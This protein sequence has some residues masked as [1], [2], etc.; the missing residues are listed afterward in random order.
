MKHVYFFFLLFA[1][2]RVGAQAVDDTATTGQGFAVVIPV[3]ANDNF[4]EATL[5]TISILSPAQHGE[6]AIEGNMTPAPDDDTILYVPDPGFAGEDSFVYTVTLVGGTTYS[7][8]VSI[9][10]VGDAGGPVANP[11]N[12]WGSEDTPMILDILANDSFGSEGPGTFVLGE[13]QNGSTAV[14]LQNDTPND[15]T[16]DTILYTP[17][18]NFNG[19]D[20]FNYTITSAFGDASTTEVSITVAPDISEGPF[21]MDDLVNTNIDTPVEII[22]LMNDSLG[23]NDLPVVSIAQPPSNGVVTL[24]TF[25]TPYANDDTF[26]Y[27]PNSGFVGTD[28]FLYAITDITGS[29]YATVTVIVGGN[30]ILLSAFYDND[31]DGVQDENETN[32]DFGTF[33]YEVNG[34]GI[35]HQV[36]ASNG[37]YYIDEDDPTAVYD[38]GYAIYPS[39]APYYTVTPGSYPNVSITSTGLSEYKFAISAALFSEVGVYL[40]PYTMP[41]PGFLYETGILLRNNG[42]QTVSGTLTFAHDPALSIVSVSENTANVTPAGFTYSFADL[43]PNEVRWVNVTMQVPVIPTVT[44]GQLVFNSAAVAVASDVNAANDTASYSQMIVGSYD[45]NDITEAHGSKI[46]VDGFTASDYLTYTIR[47]ENTG[48]ANA[49]FVRV[50]NTLDAQLNAGTLEMVAA[51]HPYVLERN[52]SQL[53]WRFNDIQLP[54]SEENTQIGHGYITY[55]IKPQ[56]GYAVGDIIPNAASIYF[57]FNPAIET[58]VFETQFVEAMGVADN[59]KYAITAWPNPVSEVFHVKAQNGLSVDRIEVLDAVGRIV[60]VG[61]GEEVNVRSL[62]SGTYFARLTVDGVQKVVKLF[63]K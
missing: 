34:D 2:S 7:A 37:K 53:T 43:T 51:S 54:P 22:M 23:G 63:K 48:T 18:P 60:L 56:P 31:A 46:V 29:A 24:N 50:E 13:L 10:V 45:P 26:T 47:F 35:M 38:L 20:V 27:T 58:N 15:P 5:E 49:E 32:L 62:P 8:T 55:R 42:T 30:G 61:N 40:V 44:L 21:A 16:D 17:G 12:F 19:V 59:M 39:F 4:S 9:I 36:A 14:I 1:V 28:T 3:L 25:D 52:G 11:D 57:D 6:V 41:R 33:Q